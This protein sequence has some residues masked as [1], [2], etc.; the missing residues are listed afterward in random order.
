MPLVATPAATAAWEKAHGKLVY[1]GAWDLARPGKWADPHHTPDLVEGNPTTHP[2]A[3]TAALRPPEPARNKPQHRRRTKPAVRTQKQNGVFM[4]DIM[5]WLEELSPSLQ[6][7]SPLPQ[8]PQR[9]PTA[10]RRR[11]PRP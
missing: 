10:P 2:A 3:E 1:N 4:A 9:A 5:R 8:E 11:A 7:L 6:E